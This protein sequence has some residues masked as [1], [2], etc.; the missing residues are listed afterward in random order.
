ML[1][2]EGNQCGSYVD[3]KLA[4]G[5][6]LHCDSMSGF[7]REEKLKKL[8]AVGAEVSTAPCRDASLGKA[9]ILLH[10]YMQCHSKRN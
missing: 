6:L 2:T 7:Q 4:L 3:V 9:S 10:K 8:T 1:G 5:L